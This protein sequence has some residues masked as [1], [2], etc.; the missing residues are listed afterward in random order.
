MK[1]LSA[2]LIL[3]AIAFQLVACTGDIVTGTSNDAAETTLVPETTAAPVTAAGEEIVGDGSAVTVYGNGVSPVMIASSA[4]PSSA[5][6]DILTIRGTLRTR[7]GKTPAYGSDAR[8][9]VDTE[10]VF[11]DTNRAITAQ[12]KEYLPTL[13]GDEASFVIYFG[14]DGVAVV[15]NHDYGAMCG[16]KYFAENYL[17]DA[18]LSA[19]AGTRYVGHISIA[20]YAEQLRLAEEERLRR[21]E[22]ERQERA[23]REWASRFDVISDSATR[24]AVKD[25]YEE[26][27]DPEAMIRWWAG[28][29][30]PDLGAFYYANS[31]RDTKGY[32]PDME[33]TYQ[34]VQRLRVLDPNSDLANFLGPDITAKMITFYQS[35]Q[36]PDDGY[37]YHPQWSKAVS[38]RNEMRYTRDQ[39][40]AITVLGWLHSAPLYPTALDRAAGTAD[41]VDVTVARLASYAGLQPAQAADW[42][43]NVQSVTSYVTNLLNTKTCESWSNTLQTQL[44]AFEA[45]GMLDAVLDVL[46]AKINPDYGLWVSRYDSSKDRYYNLMKTPTSEVPYGIFTCAYKVMIMYNAGHRLVPHASKMVA[47]AIKAINSRDPGARVTY[48]FNPWATLGNVRENLVYY[49]T[50]AMV[51]DYDAQIKA[52]VITMLDSLKGSLGK[53]KRADGSYS[54]LQSGSQSTIYGT[55]VSTGAKEGDVNGNNLVV[56]FAMHICHTIGLQHMIPVFGNEHGKLMQELLATAPKITKK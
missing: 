52:N 18:T 15:W 51:A 31:A 26:F 40:W 24:A 20:A 32:L 21:E 50:S 28:L 49:G 14:E 17:G 5:V 34:I 1:R 45:T 44:S 25:F 43:P 6:D 11:G 53:Y 56:S 47:N 29:Y 41:V 37:F 38:R 10:I 36:D 9:K 27:Y 8:E 7:L 30:D 39:D 16:V 48:I 35:K 23:A 54:Y 33:S 2:L 12:A 46:D 3:L 19:P 42:Q 22:Q 13:A 55:Q 4:I